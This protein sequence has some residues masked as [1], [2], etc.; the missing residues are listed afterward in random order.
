MPLQICIPWSTQQYAKSWDNIV[1]NSLTHNPEESLCFISATLQIYKYVKAI[2][3]INA[4]E[5]TL[6]EV[7]EEHLYE[8]N[9]GPVTSMIALGFTWFVYK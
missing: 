7:I 6:K 3:K 2:R 8:T 9:S 4:T 5:H 1:F